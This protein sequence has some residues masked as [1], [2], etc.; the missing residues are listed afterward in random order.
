MKNY[1]LFCF[2]SHA[3]FSGVTYAQLAQVETVDVMSLL[4]VQKYQAEFDALWFDKEYFENDKNFEKLRHILLHLMKTVGKMA[5]YCEMQEHGK[6]GNVDELIHAVLPDLYM[7]AL[8]LANLL[9]TDLGVKYE[10]RIA[11]LVERNKNI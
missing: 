3:S 10:E 8:Q 11:F 1:L 9:Q 2:V 7:H 4:E 6:Q 5:T